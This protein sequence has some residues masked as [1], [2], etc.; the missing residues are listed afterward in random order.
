MSKEK[1]LLRKQLALLAEQSECAVDREASDNAIA[2]CR[3]YRT[4]VA[5]RLVLLTALSAALSFDLAVHG[6]VQIVKLLRRET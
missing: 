3:I 1:E 2:M 6:V 5:E 4:L